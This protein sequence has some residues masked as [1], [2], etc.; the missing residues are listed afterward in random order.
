MGRNTDRCANLIKTPVISTIIGGF[1]V[2]QLPLLASAA[3]PA[4]SRA[5]ISRRLAF[6][7]GDRE[8]AIELIDLGDA[9]A[10]MA[11]NTRIIRKEMAASIHE[12][13]AE[14]RRA[15]TLGKVGC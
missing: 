10:F 12:I 14:L 4:A 5:S 13:P 1:S 8:T 11:M 3:V 6:Y 7:L 9:D 2:R 15:A